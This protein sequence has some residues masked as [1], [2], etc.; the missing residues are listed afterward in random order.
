MMFNE[1]TFGKSEAMAAPLDCRQ[2][3]NDFPPSFKHCEQLLNIFG[4]SRRESRIRSAFDFVLCGAIIIIDKEE[5]SITE[6]IMDAVPL[7]Y[8]K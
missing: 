3:N 7:E 2:R 5:V 8:G 6:R 1:S 4:E